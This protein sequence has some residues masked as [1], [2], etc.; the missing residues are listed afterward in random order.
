MSKLEA[1]IDKA[2]NPLVKLAI[3]TAWYF[4][5]AS[6]SYG[7]VLLS[8]GILEE[9]QSGWIGPNIDKLSS[10]FSSVLSVLGTLFAVVSIYAPINTREPES[11]TKTFTAPIIFFACIITLFLWFVNKKPND[12][13]FNGIAML[14][15][16][17]AVLRLLSH[18]ERRF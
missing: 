17:I 18:E 10:P 6:G 14:G 7:F 15:I 11:Q 13:V 1:F 3:P 9:F 12:T 4:G 2:F 8:F 5:L 16:S